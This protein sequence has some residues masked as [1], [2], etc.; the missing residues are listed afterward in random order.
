[1]LRKRDKT[2]YINNSRLKHI[3]YLELGR[4]TGGPPFRWHK[5][6]PKCI[7]QASISNDNERTKLI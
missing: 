2:V 7:C 1:M 6:L 3:N 4:L 5:L